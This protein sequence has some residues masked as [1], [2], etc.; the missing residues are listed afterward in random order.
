MLIYYLKYHRRYCLF[1]ILYEHILNYD[2]R[3]LIVHV[4][5]RAHILQNKITGYIHLVKR[6]L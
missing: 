4:R 2:I 6:V 3:N 5:M 1:H